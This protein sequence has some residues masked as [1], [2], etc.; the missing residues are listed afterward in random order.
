VDLHHFLKAGDDDKGL[1]PGSRR[2]HGGEWTKSFRWGCW[3]DKD[4]MCL[5][6]ARDAPRGGCPLPLQAIAQRK[7]DALLDRLSRAGHTLDSAAEVGI[8]ARG[9]GRGK[10]ERLQII[11]V[12]KGD[13]ACVRLSLPLGGQHGSGWDCNKSFLRSPRLT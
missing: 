2:G 13:E 6:F 4:P 12:G 8:F 3:Q 11:A 9:P 5:P 10:I 7:S 1:E